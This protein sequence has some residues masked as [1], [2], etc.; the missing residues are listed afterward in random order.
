MNAPFGVSSLR[1]EILWAIILIVLFLCLCVLAIAL[2]AV[3]LHVSNGRIASRRARWEVVWQRR[4]IE[5]LVAGAPSPRLW[6]TV[7]SRDGLYFVDFLLK[8]ACRLSGEERD[9]LARLA[10]PFLPEVAARAGARDPAMRG[11]A[12]HTLGFL[13]PATW[14]GRVV[15]ALDDPA[16]FVALAAARALAGGNRPE[17]ARAILARIERFPREGVNQLASLLSR[18]GPL[19]APVLREALEDRGNPP[20]TRLVAARALLYL[21]DPAA[22]T[23]LPRLL[24]FEKDRDLLTALLDLAQAEGG[25]E[26]LPTVRRML[27]SSDPFSRIHAVSALGK[28]GGKPDVEHLMAALNDPSAWVALKAARGLRARGETDSLRALARSGA[29]RASLGRQMLLEEVA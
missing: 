25:G 19:A 15:C 16:P 12:I 28:I 22:G 11:R 24:P 14:S 6:T 13:D 4:L 2:L 26:I 5:V 27:S 18:I 23:L 21:R 17:Q 3:S 7:R 9:L 1:D 29:P 10:R 8:H 20:R